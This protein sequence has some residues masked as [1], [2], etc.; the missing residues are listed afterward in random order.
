MWFLV[1]LLFPEVYL[2]Y[3]LFKDDAGPEPIYYPE[4]GTRELG[5]ILL[6]IVLIAFIYMVAQRYFGF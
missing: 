4:E 2:I 1:A 3:V 5:N 6:V